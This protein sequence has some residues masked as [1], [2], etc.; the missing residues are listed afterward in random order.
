VLL[1]ETGLPFVRKELRGG[2]LVKAD[3]FASNFV[4]LKK[5]LKLNRSLKQLRKLGASLLD[6]H[7]TYGRFVQYFLGHSPRTVADKN[8]RLPSQEL[9]DAAVTWLGQQLGQV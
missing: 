1:T 4:H 7:P 5:R 8:Y 9:F 2:K 3:G 6:T